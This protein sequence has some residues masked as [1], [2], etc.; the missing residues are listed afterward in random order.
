M[1]RKLLKLLR[2][3][4]GTWISKNALLYDKFST[5]DAAPITSPRTCEPGPGTL[6]FVQPSNQ[7]SI[8]NGKLV[9]A[10]VAEYAGLASTGTLSVASGVAS[11]AK[12]TSWTS[13]TTVQHG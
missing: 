4:G 12:I 8:A 1:S 2:R 9:S 6:T 7:L 11:F 3:G 10:A 5:P 13:G